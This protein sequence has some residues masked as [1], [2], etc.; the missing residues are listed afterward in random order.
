MSCFSRISAQAARHCVPNTDL[1]HVCSQSCVPAHFKEE[2]V[3]PGHALQLMFVLLQQVNVTFL[4][5]KLQQL[6]RTKDSVSP[7]VDTF[8]SFT[9]TLTPHME[10][11]QVLSFLLPCPNEA[12][13]LTIEK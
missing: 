7:D 3:S 12:I 6:Q 2:A 5:D 10:T 13:F 4:W 11:V 9:I 8:A 1:L